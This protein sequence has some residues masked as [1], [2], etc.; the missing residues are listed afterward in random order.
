VTV[1]ALKLPPGPRGSFLVGNTLAYMRDPLGFLTRVVREYG[2][3][4]RLRLGTTTAYVLAHPAD[5]EA[6]LRNQ[7]Q[8]F[9]KDK[10]TRL[11]VP[12]V[13][14][15][16][17]TSEGDL[18]RRQRRAIQ[19]AFPHQQVERYGAVMVDF[20]LR[21]L[22]SWGDGRERDVHAELM[23]LTLGI[24]AKVLFDAEVAGEAGDVGAALEVMMDYYLDPT[25]WL[26]I[27]EWLPTP[28]TLRFRR[29]LR[30]LDAIILGIIR[31]RREGGARRGG[32]P[33]SLAGGAR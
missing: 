30:R 29:A 11:L 13:G 7:Q 22:E 19:P 12:I 6:V 25:K 1:A 14:R 10:L 27:R 33:L 16:L 18:W 8:E 23:A 32:P 5:I 15:G 9:P 3:V 4:V 31:R 17:L 20:T 2:D 28:S 24:V 21:M 26:R